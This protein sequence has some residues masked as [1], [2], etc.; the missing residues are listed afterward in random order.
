[1]RILVTLIALLALASPVVAQQSPPTLSVRV[2]G[3]RTNVFSH[4][5]SDVELFPAQRATT[6]SVTAEGKQVRAV[7]ADAVSTPFSSATRGVLF[8]YATQQ[9]GVTTGEISF[10]TKGQS[11]LA[12][13]RLD[14]SLH[15]K[16][17]MASG[18]YVVEAKTP[19]IFLATLR[20]LEKNPAVA[21]VEP[22]IQYGRVQVPPSLQ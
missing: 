2:V 22:T 14:P 20:A 13:V 6:V 4:R 3:D 15:P 10:M 8:N 11:N 12:G 9:Y 17:I 18:V 1:M 16:Q 21:W 7:H 19:Q 5:G